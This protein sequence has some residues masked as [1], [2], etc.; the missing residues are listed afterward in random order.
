MGNLEISGDL[1]S[2]ALKTLKEKTNAC[3]TVTQMNAAIRATQTCAIR[4]LSSNHPDSDKGSETPCVNGLESVH[5][6][7]DHCRKGKSCKG[8]WFYDNGRCC[9]KAQY[10]DKFTKKI[11]GGGFYDF[12]CGIH[13]IPVAPAC[14]I[15]CCSHRNGVHTRLINL[16]TRSHDSDP[17]W[18]RIRRWQK[19][20]RSKGVL[21]PGI[22]RQGLVFVPPK[23]QRLKF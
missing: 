1:K 20:C 4:K 10:S 2:D 5:A 19:E 12:D 7:F 15:H 3:V 14:R 9:P 23:W 17:I 8:F 13:D 6:C 18:H 16:Y 11:P 22:P 21:H